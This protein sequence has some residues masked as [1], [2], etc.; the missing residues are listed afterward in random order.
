MYIYCRTKFKLSKTNILNR[1]SFHFHCFRC[2]RDIQG[3]YWLS[4]SFNGRS[5]G[6]RTNSIVAPALLIE[7]H[8]CEL[9]NRQNKYIEYNQQKVSRRQSSIR[10]RRQSGEDFSPKP[11]RW[12]IMRWVAMKWNYVLNDRIRGCSPSWMI[13]G[14]PQC[15]VEFCRVFKRNMKIFIISK[16]YEMEWWD[17]RLGV[18]KMEYTMYACV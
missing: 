13:S 15:Q 4:I 7:H 17:G 18:D 12:N 14:G 10:S 8:V 11:D 3:L 16:W 1:I 2:C 9:A 6:R 5:A